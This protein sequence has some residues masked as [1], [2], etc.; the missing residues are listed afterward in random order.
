[1]RHLLNLHVDTI[2]AKGNGIEGKIAASL[3]FASELL[4][5]D[6]AYGSANPE[7]AGRIEKMK[8]Q[9]AQYLAHEYFNADWHPMPFATMAGWLAPAKVQFACSARYFENMEAVRLSAE[10]QVFLKKIPDRILRQSTYD[11]MVNQQFRQDYWIK[12]PRHLDNLSRSEMLRSQKVILS[13]ADAEIPAL[14]R[15]A[16]TVIDARNIVELLAARQ[17]KTLGEL[18]TAVKPQGLNLTHVLEAV[19]ALVEKNRLHTVQDECGQGVA[20]VRS[21]RLNRHLLTQA[22]GNSNLGY[23]ASP[24]TGGGIAV[25]HYHQLFLLAMHQGMTNPVECARFVWDLMSQQGCGIV[26]DGVALVTAEENL[27]EL[28]G[29]AKKFSSARLPTLKA[30]GVV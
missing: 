9:P 20:A 5:T 18:E 23:L 21:A 4:A 3:D 24:L 16:Q 28:T 15:G 10:Q 22:R 25:E 6:T 29:Y 26:K 17:V 19:M 7:V 27:A 11:F 30:L 2:G 14:L 1:M 8:E 12:G 13:S